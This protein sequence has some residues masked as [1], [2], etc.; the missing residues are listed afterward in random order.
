MEKVRDQKVKE[1]VGTYTSVPE[2]SRSPPLPVWPSCRGT[3]RDWFGYVRPAFR[4]TGIGREIALAL[5]EGAL[6]KFRGVTLNTA[7]KSVP[8]WD[9]LGFVP[10]ARDG[11]THVCVRP[12]RGFDPDRSGS[13]ITPE[14]IELCRGSPRVNYP[15]F[16]AL[17]V[18]LIVQLL[19][20]TVGHR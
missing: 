13:L 8:F 6:Q 17:C 2:T 20:E 9:T 16:P 3:S 18:G 11:H 10:Q 7:V 19:K 4:R 14:V 1:A 12:S 15:V 5:L